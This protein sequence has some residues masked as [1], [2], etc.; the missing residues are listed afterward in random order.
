MAVANFERLPADAKEVLGAEVLARVLSKKPRPQDLWTLTR[1]GARKPF[2]GPVDRVVPAE[3]AARWVREILE[4]HPVA[5][6]SVAHAVVHLAARTGDRVR[7][8]PREMLDRVSAWLDGLE[9]AADRFR[10]LLLRPESTAARDEAA[11]LFGESLPVGLRLAEP[12]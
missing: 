11:W 7:D 12:S 9:G 3:T 4:A 5:E 8:L 1:L 6:E 10:D 2:Y